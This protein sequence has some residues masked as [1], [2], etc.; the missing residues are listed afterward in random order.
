MVLARS[1]SINFDQLRSTSINFDQLRSKSPGNWTK[2]Q[3]TGQK[4]RKL[5]KSPGNWTRW[6]KVAQCHGTGGTK[7]HRWDKVAQVG[8]SGT[9]QCSMGIERWTYAHMRIGA[10]EW[11]TDVPV[12]HGC[13]TLPRASETGLRRALEG[14][15]P[16]GR[17]GLRRGVGRAYGAV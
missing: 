13:P 17:I 9:P 2:V 16:C 7:W 12:R 5:D 14:L 11:D 1:T 3:E 8:Q 6:D 15:R 4:S 10:Y